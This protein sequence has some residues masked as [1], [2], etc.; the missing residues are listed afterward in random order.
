MTNYQN[1]YD[2]DL[3]KSIIIA[4][5]QSKNFKKR[6]DACDNDI[7]NLE[8]FL[9]NSGFGNY[10]K[11]YEKF[12]LFFENGKIRFNFDMPLIECTVSIRMLAYPFLSDFLDSIVKYYVKEK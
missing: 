6:L 11:E 1:F 12:F 5:E 7:K 9:K 8:K 4:E 10:K 3:Q 2:E